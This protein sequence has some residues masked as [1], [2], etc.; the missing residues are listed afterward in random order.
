MAV[1]GLCIVLAARKHAD[2]ERYAA[3]QRISAKDPTLWVKRA[4]FYALAALCLTIPSGCTQ[5]VLEVFEA[6]REATSAAVV[7]CGDSTGREVS[8]S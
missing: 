6:R 8:Y 2:P 7:G 1:V 3:R 4:A 5:Q